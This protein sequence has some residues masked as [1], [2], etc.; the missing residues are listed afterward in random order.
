MCDINCVLPNKFV[1]LSVLH[2]KKFGSVF[3]LQNKICGGGGGLI[4]VE[5]YRI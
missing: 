2:L 3:V 4:M 5:R 1:F